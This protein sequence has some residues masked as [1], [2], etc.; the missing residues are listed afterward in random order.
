MATTLDKPPEAPSLEEELHQLEEEENKLESRASTLELNTILIALLG[1]FAL[2]FSIA[3]L[4]VALIRTGG[5]NNNTAAPA[6]A[7]PAATGSAGMGAGMMSGSS[8]ASQTAPVVN[9]AHVITAQL[10]EMF[11]RPSVTSVPAGKVTFQA[12]NVGKVMHEL[13]VERMPM[14]FDSPGHPTESAAQGMIEDMD[15]GHSGKM[16][17]T[18]KP[19]KYMLFCNV[20]GHYAAGQHTVLTV[21]RS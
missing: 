6:A 11:V 13:M 3:A 15:P 21:T 14:K 1:G 4:A 5:N 19:G 18:L 10:G 20:P 9:G 8:G 17:L 2:L 7:A 16:T 12:K